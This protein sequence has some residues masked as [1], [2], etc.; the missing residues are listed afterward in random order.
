MAR[1]IFLKS[2]LPKHLSDN[3]MDQREAQT[4]ASFTGERMCPY[5][6]ISSAL[7]PE[8]LANSLLQKRM[9][10]ARPPYP[11]LI[12]TRLIKIRITCTKHGEGNREKQIEKAGGS[13]T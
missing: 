7:W 4:L 10:K 5:L 12:L 2:Q 8:Y 11:R 3:R 6:F 9:T 1:L 13:P